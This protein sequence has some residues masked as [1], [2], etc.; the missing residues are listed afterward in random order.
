MTVG[1]VFRILLAVVAGAGLVL[2]SAFSDSIVRPDYV[3][4]HAETLRS[5]SG[6]IEGVSMYDTQPVRSTLEV[7][8]LIALPLLGLTGAAVYAASRV[9]TAKAVVGGSASAG[10][11]LI[12]LGVIHAVEWRKP[13][14]AYFP[15]MINVLI[16]A[17]LGFAVGAAASWVFTKAWPNKS[18]ER[19][20]ER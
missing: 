13:D 16:W 9:A 20:R 17:A 10:V 12:S 19:T 3:W 14:E 18:L 11:A 5:A 6:E 2:L 1:V 15:P 4:H 8:I 7:V